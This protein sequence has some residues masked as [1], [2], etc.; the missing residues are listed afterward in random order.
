MSYVFYVKQIILKN[1]RFYAFSGFYRLCRHS[2]G[3]F[4]QNALN[5][6]KYLKLLASINT[7]IW[8]EL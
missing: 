2:F 6:S 4:V 3:G 1:Y 8:G 5:R 7:N